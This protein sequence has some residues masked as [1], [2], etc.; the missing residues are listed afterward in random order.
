MIQPG[1]SKLATQEGPV[2]GI[3]GWTRKRDAD[4]HVVDTTMRVTTPENISF[5][6]EITGPFH[7]LLAYIFDVFISL[8][9]Y[10][11]VVIFLSLLF[12]LTLTPLLIWLG[13]GRF[14]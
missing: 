1:N 7:R 10:F 12:S 9:G 8:G 4:I 11:A 3:S 2:S 13:G 5:Q 6:Y 14:S